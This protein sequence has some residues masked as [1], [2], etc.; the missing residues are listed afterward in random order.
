[1]TLALALQAA[2]AALARWGAR[3]VP[4]PSWRHAG[5]TTLAALAALGI[6]YALELDN[7][8][9]AAVTVMLV[10]HPVHGMVLAKSISRFI[11]TLAGAAVAVLL[12]GW[13]AQTPELFLLGL[14][15][16]MGLCCLGSTLLR[17]FR[18][19]GTVL[20]GYTVVLIALPAADAPQQMFALVT[21]R[22]SDVTI[23]IVC[24]GLVAALLTSRSA[25]QGL[26]QKFCHGLAQ[27]VAY[28]RTALTSGDEAGLARLRPKLAADIA[29][30]DALVEF[31]ATETAE[32]APLRDSLRIALA[33][34]LG[35]LGAG[36]SVQ[37][38]LQRAEA[39][40]RAEDLQA[41]IAETLALLAELTQALASGAGSKGAGARLTDLYRRLLAL[42]ARIEAGLTPDNVPLLV[43]ADRLAELLDELRIGLSG[44]I[45][46]AQGHPL[47]LGQDLPGTNFH[48]K[49]FGL[50]LDWRAGLI[51]ALRAAL[52]VWLAGAL[53]LLPAWPY[54]WNLIMV[55][56]PNAGLLAT[57]DHP[58]Q[59]A[60]EFTKGCL[61]ALVLGWIS[62]IY[63]LP[64]AD[65][66]WSLCLVLAPFLF[67]GVLL[68]V[69]PKTIFIGVGLSVFYLT[70]LMPTN[71]MV[72][73][74]SL[75]LNYALP[76]LAG[77]VL[78]M[79]VFRLLLPN[80]P[81]GH[82]RSV[83]RVMRRDLQALLTRPLAAMPAEAMPAD[84]ET[85]MHDR[86][87]YL[88]ARLRAAEMR[89]SGLIRGGFA[90]L[91]VG[92]EI[93]RAR[94]LLLPLAGDRLVATAMAPAR[95]DLQQLTRAPVRAIQGLRRSAK[96]LL[97]LAATERP[98]QAAV[99]AQIAAS[100]IEVA[101]LLGQNRRFFQWGTAEGLGRGL[102]C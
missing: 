96:A 63:L 27:V 94:R 59:D 39:A 79:L 1:M 99:L 29:A 25:V 95:Q 36:A 83:V 102:P 98:E 15:L 30:L 9:S 61:L 71:P 77:A 11:G 46:L 44:M 60:V 97:F 87:L 45:A 93:I 88:I 64:L 55:V 47:V 7:P 10:A 91:R 78:S 28:A 26:N 73:D 75:Y 22:V 76:T 24:S 65:G 92:R 69:L 32:V 82:V 68:S 35:A 6:A 2:P 37:G 18:S 56:V 58:E 3:L 100:L 34:M 51:N 80:D 21:S 43:A 89:H 38:A 12:M 57:R 20:A 50:H 90:A 40:G 85:R 4:P 13:F 42:A 5:R 17:N 81:R 19:Y 16:W 48:P 41:V 66:F 31:A 23:G 53:W 8:F 49:S 70:L 86:M 33:A 52:A 84:W 62:L 101:L 14:G 67:G 54:G 72:Y 74:A